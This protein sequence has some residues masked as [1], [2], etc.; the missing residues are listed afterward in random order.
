MVSENC[1]KGLFGYC[2]QKLFLRIIFENIKN[3]ILMFLGP[4][5]FIFLKIVLENGLNIILMFSENCS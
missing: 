5:W 3:I 2:F 4:V 1:F